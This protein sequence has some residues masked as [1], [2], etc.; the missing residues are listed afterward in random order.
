[1]KVLEQV[2]QLVGGST[3]FGAPYEKNGVAVIP[4]SSF[5]AG[6]GGG[7]GSA[8]DSQGSGEGGGAGVMAR[9][10][11]VFVI[12][13]DNVAWVPAFDLNRVILMGQLVVLAAILSWRSVARARARRR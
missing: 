9:P 4:A 1:M 11:G 7:E 5:W 12:K 13:G 3:V 8:P 6:G 10:A 2:K